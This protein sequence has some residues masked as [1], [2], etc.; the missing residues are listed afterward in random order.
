M[1]LP[2]DR[3]GTA[4]VLTALL[5]RLTAEVA[6]RGR[7]DLSLVAMNSTM[8]RDRRRAAAG[9]HLDQEWWKS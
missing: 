4:E 1:S 8:Y 9:T 3:P 7:V 5:E 6:R 2:G